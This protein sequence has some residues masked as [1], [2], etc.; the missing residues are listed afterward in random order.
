MQTIVKILYLQS[1]AGLTG[2]EKDESEMT[3]AEKKELQKKRYTVH[4]YCVLYHMCKYSPRQAARKMSDKGR[5]EKHKQMEEDREKVRQQLR[6]KVVPIKVKDWIKF[7]T[8][9]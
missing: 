3:D 7:E 5:R 6:E 4:S 1:L 8:F 2:E 9:F